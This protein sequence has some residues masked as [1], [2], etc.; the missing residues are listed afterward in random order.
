M[1]ALST[2]PILLITF[3]SGAAL[4]AV[5][6]YR[7]SRGHPPIEGGPEGR[8]APDPWRSGAAA[9]GRTGSAVMVSGAGLFTIL[10]GSACWRWPP[11]R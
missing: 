8:M 7:L 3:L 2:D 10:G 1:T 6:A 9:G 11:W 4:A 5:F